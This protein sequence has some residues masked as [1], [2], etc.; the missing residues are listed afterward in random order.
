MTK[1]IFIFILAVLSGAL[2]FV[3]IK[4]FP[5]ER[6]Q[7]IAAFPVKKE[8][9]NLWK[10]INF[11]Y[12]GLLIACAQTGAISVFI[13]LMGSVNVPFLNIIL[14]IGILIGLCV[15]AAKIFARIIEK[16]MHTFTVGGASFLGTIIAPAAVFIVHRTLA[17]PGDSVTVMLPFLTASAISYAFGEGLGR[18]ACISFGCCYGKPVKGAGPF[19]ERLFTRCYFAFSGKTKKIAY[20]AGLDG[21]K[22][23]P[24]QAMTSVLFV[25]TGI[26]SIY[27]FLSAR[28]T[29]AYG[30]TILATQGWRFV[31]ETMRADF[32]GKG[33]F[34]M[35][36]I[37]AL[38]SCLYAFLLAVFLPEQGEMGAP[39]VSNGLRY[40]WSPGVI[41]SI[42]ALWAAMFVYFGQSRVT[43]STI[44][45][46]A[47]REKI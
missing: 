32:R 34:S 19:M 29:V 20:E 26:I 36:Q 46:F 40:L 15:P 45:L 42:Q 18:L 27:L 37:M 8:E 13:V 5:G 16:K 25:A 43:G 23:I 22:V 38:L 47:D 30:L 24:V 6:W 7:V 31:S 41:I 21:H 14:F 2:L 11:T 44:S 33:R 12:Y 35:Y 10:G 39:D 17:V 1:E 4:Y 9:N 3:G 28:Y